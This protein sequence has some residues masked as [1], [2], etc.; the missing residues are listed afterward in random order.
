MDIGQPKDYI[1]GKL[2]FIF[3]NR[4]HQLIKRNLSL[5]VTL[6]CYPLSPPFGPRKEQMGLWRK[7]P[8]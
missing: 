3:T 2:K 5:L 8:R 6:D 4:Y 7:R 1:A